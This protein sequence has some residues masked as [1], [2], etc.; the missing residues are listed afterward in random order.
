M[1]RRL[2]CGNTDVLKKQILLDEKTRGFSFH[3]TKAGAG[4]HF[5]LLD[6]KETAST[7]GVFSFAYT[8]ITLAIAGNLDQGGLEGRGGEGPGRGT[9]PIPW[10][11]IWLNVGVAFGLGGFG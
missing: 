7:K 11:S 1:S 4:E 6:C 3:N 10:R 2:L 9:S 8:G 5:L